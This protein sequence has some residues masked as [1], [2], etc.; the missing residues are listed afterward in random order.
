MAD[1]KINT[2]LTEAEVH[3]AFYRAL[4]DLSDAEVQAMVSAEQVSRQQADTALENAVSGLQTGLSTETGAREALQ[5]IVAEQVN[6]GAKNRITTYSGSCSPPASWF[7]ISAALE[8]GT[9]VIS[10]DSLTSTDTDAQTCRGIF[11]AADGSYASSYFML[12]RGTNVSA[13]A[14]LTK[15]AVKLRIN[16]SDTVAHSEGDS[17]AY[18][19]AMVCEKALWELSPQFVPYCPTVQELYQMILE[20]NRRAARAAKKEANHA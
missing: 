19:G 16:P 4:H 1:R 7:E 5:S 8:P 17:A 14:T 13:A 11:L 9:Y 3:T 10:F 6:Q 20:Q 15:A 18:S 12:P 2:G